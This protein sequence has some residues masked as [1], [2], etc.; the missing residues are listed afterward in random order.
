MVV[1]C[2]RYDSGGKDDLCGC[3]FFLGC[4]VSLLF[5]GNRLQGRL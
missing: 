4:E 5:Q 1:Q 2:L 3:L